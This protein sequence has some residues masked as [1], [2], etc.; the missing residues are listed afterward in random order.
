[1][2]IDKYLNT[3]T[4]Y[5]IHITYNLIF[6]CQQTFLFIMICFILE[7]LQCVSLHVSSLLYLRSYP[8]MDF[9]IMLNFY[10]TIVTNGT[11]DTVIP[12]P[13]HFYLTS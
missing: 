6:L 8:L 13:L 5:I 7:H 10:L 2:C 11:V 1:M 12:S 9:Q 3:H 4:I